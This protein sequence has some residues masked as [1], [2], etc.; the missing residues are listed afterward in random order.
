[1][2]RKSNE[3]SIGEAI[4]EFLEHYRLGNKLDEVNLI[5]QWEEVAGPLVSRYTKNLFIRNGILYV[6]VESAALRNEL[7]MLRSKIIEALN[8]KAGKEIILKIVFK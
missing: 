8:K 5:H 2:I 3:Q 7:N 6:T 4:R 1:M